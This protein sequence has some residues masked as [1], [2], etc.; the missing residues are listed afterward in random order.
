MAT[1]TMDSEN[2]GLPW[3]WLIWLPV[4]AS[5]V[6][7]LTTLAIAIRHGD[8]PLPE[9]VTRTGPVLYGE[10]VGV[11]RA[12][13]FGVRGD[14]R[15]DEAA[16]GISLSLEGRELPASLSLRLWHPTQAGRDLLVPLTRGDDGIYRGAWPAGVQ[17]LRPLLSG[18]GWEL[19]GQFV[20]AGIRFA[21]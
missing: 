8:Q 9:T 15:I 18:A 20:D 21:P 10:H 16:R 1:T 13:E 19:P 12:R 3:K 7:G 14:A 6:A 11:T 2:R 5:V 17:G 4:L